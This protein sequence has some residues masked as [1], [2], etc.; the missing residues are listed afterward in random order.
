LTSFDLNNVNS[1]ISQPVQSIGYTKNIPLI[2]DKVDIPL[3]K[4]NPYISEGQMVNIL[5]EK[6]INTTKIRLEIAMALYYQNQAIH[7][8]NIKYMEQM[9]EILKLNSQESYEAYILLVTNA[10]E[11]TD[12]RISAVKEIITNKNFVNDLKDLKTTI[13]ELDQII[14]QGVE[15]NVFTETKDIEKIINTN[16]TETEEINVYKTNIDSSNSIV[17]QENV[18]EKFVK[19]I[20]EDEILV[21]SK[22]ENK[23]N[24]ISIDNTLSNISESLKQTEQI[25]QDLQNNITLDIK[26]NNLKNNLE[27]IKPQENIILNSE[28]KQK[29]S[30]AS[31]KFISEQYVP[32]DLNTYNI[33]LKKITQQINT[34]LGLKKEIFSSTSTESN[35]N[36]SK[37]EYIGVAKFTQ[38][39]NFFNGIE[40]FE[41]ELRNFGMSDDAKS[42]YQNPI[43]KEESINFKQLD[44][45]LYVEVK[46]DDNSSTSKYRVYS[47]INNLK[48]NVPYIALINGIPKLIE[49][50]KTDIKILQVNLNITDDI[51]NMMSPKQVKTVIIDGKPNLFIIDSKQ[52]KV[53]NKIN[54]SDIKSTNIVSNNEL[55]S[56]ILGKSSDSVLLQENQ[57]YNNIVFKDKPK[58]EVQIID[59]KN[60]LV[61]SEITNNKTTN[62]LNPIKN[63]LSNN[64]TEFNQ[65]PIKNIDDN[66]LFIEIPNDI[67]G[68]QLNFKNPNS[69]EVKNISKNTDD[70]I[71]KIYT[72]GGINYLSIN[73]KSNTT[74]I[75]ITDI[76]SKLEIPEININ[77][78][79]FPKTLNLINTDKPIILNE[80][81]EL[82]SNLSETKNSI[83]KN[84]DQINN[85]EVSETINPDSKIIIKTESGFKILEPTTPFKQYLQD[86]NNITHVQ[87]QEQNNQNQSLTINNN[88]N[89]DKPESVKISNN[90][91]IT[92][93]DKNNQIVTI[94]TTLNDNT[95]VDV[96]NSF[97]KTNED[98]SKNNSANN[99]EILD[100]NQNN[101]LGNNKK[102]I[103]IN[104]LNNKPVIQIIN[105]QSN[106]INIPINNESISGLENI[107]HNEQPII[108]NQNNLNSDNI[109][110]SD[111]NTSKNN[112][113]KDSNFKN[114]DQI[115][116]FEVSEN[117]TPD[118]KIIIKTESGFKV[119]E[120][121]TPFKQYLQDNNNITHIQYQEQNNQNQSLTI[122]N[123]LNI[124]KPQS[125][126]ISN[127][128]ITFLDKNNQIVTI[129]TTLNDN[130]F[131]DVT[132]S[133]FKTNDNLNKNNSSNTN[134]LLDSKVIKINGE[135][136]FFSPNNLTTKYIP[137]NED[138]INNQYIKT[139][140][141]GGKEKTIRLNYVDNKNNIQIMSNNNN[142]IIIPIND[143]IFNIDSII[144]TKQPIIINQ[145]NLNS[146]NITNYDNN[147]SEILTNNFKVS[148]S[149]TPD[150]K[151][152]I[153]TESGFKVLEPT[154]PFKQYL[155]DNNNITH[156]QY[157]EQNNQ[158]QSL[159][160]NNNL[161]IDKPESV[162]ISNNNITF[163]DKNNQIVTIPTT[164]NDNTF[165]DVTNSF[166]K[167]NED[168]NKNNSANN[169][170]ILNNKIIDV[171]GKNYLI[172]LPKTNEVLE[173]NQHINNLFALPLDDV[174]NIPNKI[175]Q[176][177]KEV[178]NFE[179]SEIK[180]NFNSN[181]NELLSESN[182]IP[183]VIN[184]L[185][186]VINKS[187]NKQLSNLNIIPL[188]EGE[189]MPNYLESSIDG[190]EFIFV[191]LEDNKNIFMPKLKA[192]KNIMEDINN[193]LVIKK[194]SLLDTTLNKSISSN[195][196]LINNEE[197]KI[198]FKSNKSISSENLSQ[199]NQS[200]TPIEENESIL[201]T[202]LDN[203]N[204][205]IP[206]SRQDLN[207]LPNNKPLILSFDKNNNPVL[208]T[209][210]I[211]FDETII[212]IENDNSDNKSPISSKNLTNNQSNISNI[213]VIHLTSKNNI[214]QGLKIENFEKPFTLI[215]SK[216]ELNPV[217]QF[218]F[219][220][221]NKLYSF[222]INNKSENLM[223]NNDVNKI[224]NKNNSLIFDEQ[225]IT[226]QDNKIFK[227]NITPELLTNAEPI[228]EG[229]NITKENGIVIY[230][231]NGIKQLNIDEIPNS[232]SLEQEA[233]FLKHLQLTQV[234]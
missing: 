43:N 36:I 132:N 150:S 153:K 72:E 74:N 105:N 155:Q 38:P 50:N 25:T 88:L 65:L 92:F 53:I 196:P 45:E 222:E 205:I 73:N 166:F 140:L 211:S 79:L 120:P 121:T 123:N 207:T 71:F 13:E 111:I 19:N 145:N 227:T 223:V 171:K 17:I 118:S 77:N 202:S 15:E 9:S 188:K 174:K 14:V 152:I 80:V 28:A 12:E 204:Y 117:I 24:Q 26:T 167:T 178:F 210:N 86:N 127:N 69:N 10:L 203:S 217:K 16:I 84:T 136:Y 129:P 183:I 99:N 2:R 234:L 200:V 151:I 218:I 191:S 192:E 195:Q 141:D 224:F 201:I 48:N 139:N 108:I 67:I 148:E 57:E 1:F 165:V 226:K 47:D 49:K 142:N 199:K 46:K 112:Q 59:N 106:I 229:F 39:Q 32:K 119:L 138:N 89:I 176:I 135:N 22:V 221:A 137:I 232:L 107:I 98:L 162:K 6:G 68:K 168:L 7:E 91:N 175:N 4:E 75:P 144:N 177:K 214:N 134:E 56:D 215:N 213:G 194:P 34:I 76:L 184:G 18:T 52:E 90:N 161:N 37:S 116:N 70:N 185:P 216:N 233:I 124:D 164:L 102:E 30:F 23:F 87:Y 97:F 122:N 206:K 101:L 180:Q 31:E 173:S 27:V 209:N 220:D 130:T 54:T 83:L 61:I 157:Q 58:Y 66:K 41:G 33:D 231:N 126:K 85:F 163:L 169:N 208:I 186:V 100:N 44:N 147:Q 212:N 64:N 160:I 96:T 94:P 159:T 225:I 125:V 172:L 113:I 181:I 81:K 143:E 198:S 146:D 170:E 154:T 51:L 158:N 128:N 40:I 114:T 219:S 228:H 104:Y 193:L 20:V 93:L 115:N 3:I 8:D 182:N 190:N 109:I 230:N 60:Y 110:N 42:S 156:V 179:Y 11:V 82:K 103:S 189:E 131:V 78:I 63:I 55:K 133:F 149:I 187:E 5:R 35:T 62:N 197:Q 29:Q 95:F 21:Q